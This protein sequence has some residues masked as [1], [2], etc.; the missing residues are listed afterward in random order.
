MK[1][2]MLLLLGLLFWMNSVL[3]E[4]SKNFYPDKVEGNRAFLVS[5]PI[6]RNAF[7]NQAAHYVYAVEGE[8]IAV[9]SSAQN[10]GQGRVKLKAPDGKIYQTR[11]DNIGRILEFEGSS[12]KAELAGPRV[13]YTPFEIPVGIGQSGIWCVEFISPDQDPINA[14]TVEVPN[15]KADAD[16]IQNTQG[17]LIS[18]WDVSVRNVDNTAW[19]VGRVFVSILQLHISTESL[20]ERDGAFYG[21]N[22]VLT[23]DGYIYHVN[24]NG[25]HGIDFA[26]FVNSSGVLNEKGLPSY[27]S[28]DQEMNALFHNP[29]KEDEQ[30]LITH[31]MFYG[32]PDTTMPKQS[33]GAFPGGRSWLFSPREI[34][35]V[36][37]LKIVWEEGKTN[38][39]EKEG[40]FLSFKTNYS[41]RYK[42]V[43]SPTSDK[44]FFR[45]LQINVEAKEGVNRFFW[46]GLDGDNN[47]MPQG[48]DYEVRVSVSLV[49]GEIHFPYF[50]M[51][52]NP[53]GILVDRIN[54]DGSIH[55]DAI[56]YWDDSDITGGQPGEVS[57]PRVNK[58]GTASRLDG[59]RW[60]SY[61]ATKHVSGSLNNGYGAY[62]YGNKRVMDTWTYTAHLQAE[63]TERISVG[64]RQPVKEDNPLSSIKELHITVYQGREVLFDLLDTEAF[65][66]IL[67]RGERIEIVDFSIYGDI[68]LTDNTATYSVKDGA[69][70][71]GDEFTYR[72]VDENGT[73]VIINKV[74]IQI[75]KTIPIAKDDFF[76]VVFN[77]IQIL[78]VLNNDFVEHSYLNKESLRIVD[79]PNNGQ[80]YKDAEGKWIYQANDQYIGVDKFAYQIMDGNG[81]W[82]NI[83]TVTLTIKGLFIPNTITPN[84]DS[85]NDTFQII[86]LSNFDQVEV[87][88]LDRSG[89][90]MF[91]SNNYKNDWVVPVTVTNGVY[92]YLFKGSKYGQKPIINKGALMI[93]TSSTSFV[94]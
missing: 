24:G 89:R 55:S 70:T 79:Y 56:M 92:F 25:S 43:I 84:G 78:D 51:E 46:D 39:L 74:Y 77:S 10:V 75:L 76:D 15:V 58:T 31:K 72:I 13:G 90:I 94:N 8:T 48:V 28:A 26:Y 60:G 27:K 36:Q 63:I 21:R 47:F 41:G 9:A 87:S 85:K 91:S 62:S 69:Y 14:A 45:S 67:E 40:V 38:Q 2:N 32:L 16:W 23:N 49:Q 20:A 82:S 80:L 68:A 33:H 11:S 88:V 73:T 44:F 12:R 34:I 4:G 17:S 5:L 59:H 52:I 3:G 7:A 54:I 30:L 29:N 42:V 19:V 83:A 6:G 81:N 18:A 1:W 65:A 61:T 71:G 57:N 22:Y 50:D 64:P 53:N 66:S 86:G 37:D 93:L 35:D